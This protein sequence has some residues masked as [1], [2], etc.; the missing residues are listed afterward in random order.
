MLAPATPP[1]PAF[2]F[3]Q[4]HMGVPVRMVLH[5]PGRVA[6]EDAARAAF[7]RIAALDRMMSDYRPDGELRRVAAGAG[8]FVAVSPELLAVVSRALEIA[9]ETGGAFDPTVAPLVTLW[10]DARAHARLPDPGRL[11][12]ARALVG[13]RRVEINPAR[14]AIRLARPGMR[15][16]IGGVAKGYILAEALR[17][18]RDN[19]VNSALLEAG[20]DI[21]AG[22]APPGRPGW[23]VD[24][25]GAS[26]AFTE[27]ASRLTNAALATSGPTSQFVEIDGV[28]YS[29]IVD[30]RTGMG[31]TS[32][33]VARVIA[34]DAA[35][36]DA[37]ATAL[38][39]PGHHDAAAL[40]ACFPGA[41]ID[42]SGS[43][44][45]ESSRPDPEKGSKAR[46]DPRERFT[47]PRAP[48]PAAA[49]HCR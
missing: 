3:T 34:A 33:I 13:W 17:T 28:R 10:R 47:A 12:A 48:G 27:R 31:V 43:G 4:V 38:T 19:A 2:E 20:G 11:A 9:R 29:H 24:V 23:R 36:A 18:L 26:P 37:L 7:A 44:P 8:R 32:G 5:A 42:L 46:P 16:D 35:L 49:S 45:P 15:L 22:D 30:P 14:S 21:V 40:Q 25:P 6:A 39:I 1:V 41:I